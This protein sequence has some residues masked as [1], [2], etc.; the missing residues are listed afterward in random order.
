MSREIQKNCPLPE[1]KEGKKKSD[2]SKKTK[3]KKN[4]KTEK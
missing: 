2:V 1:P 4:D 3:Q